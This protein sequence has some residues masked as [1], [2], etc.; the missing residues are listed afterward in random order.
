MTNPATLTFASWNIH[1]FKGEGRRPDPERTLRILRA[2]DADVVAL[3]EVDGRAHLG[4]LPQAFERLAEG[5]PGHRVEARLFGAAGREYGH[6]L[7]SR[8]PILAATIHA[9]PGPGFEPRAAIEGVVETPLGRVRVLAAHFGL[10]PQARR[11]QAAFLA[12]L[13]VPGEATVALGDFNEWR[14]EGGVHRRLSA[15]LPLTVRRPS[16]PA[17]RPLVA[18]DRLYASSD[19]RLVDAEVVAEGAPAS[20]H[21]PLKVTLRMR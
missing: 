15:V 21:R 9:L 16:W 17:R 2:I 12:G 14:G 11:A 8:W 6:L 13:A 10:R 1:G 3:Q 4:R 19:L 5:L 7:W 20:D 18:L